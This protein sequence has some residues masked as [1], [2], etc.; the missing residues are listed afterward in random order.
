MRDAISL[1]A[2]TDKRFHVI[3]SRSNVFVSNW[4]VDGNA[5]LQVGFEIKI[6]PPVAGTRPKQ[7]T[8]SNNVASDPIKALSFIIRIFLVVDIEMFVVFAKG[9][10]P[11]LHVMF[12]SVFN[13]QVEFVFEFP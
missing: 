10:M 1:A 9:P 3:I 6:T 2:Y 13:C 7:R 12:F 11:A 5:F 8:S 4:P